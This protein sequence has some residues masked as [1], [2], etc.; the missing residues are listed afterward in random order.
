MLR[1]ATRRNAAAIAAGRVTLTRAP[2]EQLPPD[3]GGSSDA[4][5][6]VN[7]PRFWP[8]PA[9][10]LDELCRRLRPGGR[11]AIAYQPAA[12]G[13]PR[14]PLAMPA[15]RWKP[16]CRTLATPRPGPRLSTWTLRWPASSPS[17]PAPPATAARESPCPDRECDHVYAKSASPGWVRGGRALAA[18]WL[19]TA[20]AAPPMA[21]LAVAGEATRDTARRAERRV[22]A[23]SP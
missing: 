11:I 18:A 2:A 13:S 9:Q 15:G 8:V 4:I 16:C 7:S 6:T 22:G 17:T 20:L 19:G 14:A 1:Q 5:L 10:R 21:A 3:L 23:R 12:Q